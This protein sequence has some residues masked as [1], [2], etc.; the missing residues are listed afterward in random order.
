LKGELLKQVRVASR[1]LR[2]LSL[3]KR[4]KVLAD[5]A[6]KI[7]K[8]KNQILRANVLDVEAFKESSSFTLALLDRLIL[9]ESRLNGMIASLEA[10]RKMPDPLGR[11]LSEKTLKNG[12]ILRQRS[13]SFGVILFIFESRPNVITEAFSLGFKSGNALIFKNG[14]EA[15]HT[16][17]LLYGLIEE[18]LQEN[19]LAKESFVGLAQ[20]AREEVHWFLK[21]DAWIDLVIPRGGDQLIETV[22]ANSRIPV[23]QNDRGLCHLYVDSEADIS[24]ALQVLKNGKT[25]RPSVCNSLETLLVHEK[26]AQPFLSLAQKELSAEQVIWWACP[27]ALTLLGGPSEKVRAANADSFDSEYLSL[28]LNCRVVKNLNEALD[29]ILQFGSN[30]SESIITQNEVTA[31]KFQDKV[32]AAVVYW[33]ASTRFTD[34]VEF[35][36]GGE[37][38]ISTQKLHVRGPVGLDALTT[39]RWVVDGH[40]QIRP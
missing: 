37:I 27:Q 14:K 6:Q 11:I 17:K 33:N 23:I 29:H 5:L 32:D 30:H 4:N 12:L 16:A 22:K 40:G 21:Q 36:L 26:I 8:Q 1:E 15:Y 9:T 28:Q 7:A 19:K 34:G 20:L 3:A 2:S 13:D 31:R 25:Q 38:G 24:M 10:V 18:T 39:V 35:G